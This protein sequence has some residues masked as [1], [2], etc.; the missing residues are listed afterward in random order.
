M[1][2][3]SCNTRIDYRFVTNC[4]ECG[5]AV[6]PAGPSEIQTLP[7]FQPAVQVE[8]RLGWK[9]SL[10]NVV[11]VLVGSVAGMIS[12]AVTM[13]FGA[14]V[15]YLALVSDVNVDPSTACARG[16][17]IAALSILSG[18]FLGTMG[19]SAFTIKHPFFRSKIH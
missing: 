14:A 2:C 16:T 8:K 9:K 13:Y 1:N 12:G 6:E 11:Y 4:H 19:G 15:F 7:D 5:R 10:V 17:A 3:Q 18:G